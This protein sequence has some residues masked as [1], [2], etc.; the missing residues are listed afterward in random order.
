MATK[1]TMWF[2][3]SAEVPS[4]TPANKLISVFTVLIVILQSIVA[5]LRSLEQIMTSLARSSISASIMIDLFLSYYTDINC[6]LGS[7]QCPEK[8]SLKIVT[9]NVF[10]YYQITVLSI[11]EWWTFAS[12]PD[13]NI[14]FQHHLLF[15]L[16]PVTM[17]VLLWRGPFKGIQIQC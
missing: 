4:V 11:N 15:V 13:V 17:P 12:P 8:H 16:F 1:I 2:W 9:R 5:S 7:V 6:V 3:S 10:S 14:E